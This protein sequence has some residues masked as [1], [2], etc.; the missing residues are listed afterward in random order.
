MF[1][2]IYPEIFRNRT[3][4]FEPYIKVVFERGDFPVI[5]H[6]SEKVNLPKDRGTKLKGLRTKVYGSQLPK[7]V[8]FL[9]LFSG[10]D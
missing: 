1:F 10:N 8:V 2:E 7:G 4:S 5:L 6:F 3:E 9:C